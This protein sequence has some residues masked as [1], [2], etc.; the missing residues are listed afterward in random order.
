MNSDAGKYGGS[1]QLNE[2]VFT[3]PNVWHNQPYS[4]ELKLPPLACVYL[5]WKAELDSE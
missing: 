4:L 1:G 2:D 5:Q 3:Q